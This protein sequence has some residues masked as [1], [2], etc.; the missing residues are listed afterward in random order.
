M[1]LLNI[2]FIYDK[3]AEGPGVASGKLFLKVFQVKKK[4]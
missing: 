4:C 1:S 2:S 3:L